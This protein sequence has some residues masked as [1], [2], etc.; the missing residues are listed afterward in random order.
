M[1]SMAPFL[2]WLIESTFFNGI[3][4]PL[5]KRIYNDKTFQL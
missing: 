2:T 1:D 4:Q 5:I 3:I